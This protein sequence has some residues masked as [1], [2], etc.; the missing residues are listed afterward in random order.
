[1]L[2]S[3]RLPDLVTA[4][5]HRAAVGDNPFFGFDERSKRPFHG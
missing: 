4:R 1:M 3:K 5:F 2:V